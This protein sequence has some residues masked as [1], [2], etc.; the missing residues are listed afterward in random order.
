MAEIPLELSQKVAEDDQ[1]VELTGGGRR[2][3]S[4][5]RARGPSLKT[6]R[7]PQGGGTSA[8]ER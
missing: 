3:A 1:E 7:C 2:V 6:A 8:A 4:G 5:M